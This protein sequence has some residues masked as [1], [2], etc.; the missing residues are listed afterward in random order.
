MSKVLLSYLWLVKHI[1]LLVLVIDLRG[2]L[3]YFHIKFG[4]FLQGGQYWTIWR[5][6]VSVHVAMCSRNSMI[7]R[8][9]AMN[10]LVSS[11]EMSLSWSGLL[12]VQRCRKNLSTL[13]WED[14]RVLSQKTAYLESL[15]V[16]CPCRNDWLSSDVDP[17]AW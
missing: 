12:E 6:P 10:W 17:L 13:L 3:W 9:G 8:A 4:V 16:R 1:V 5:C 14:P 15:L 2:L 11:C 7:Y